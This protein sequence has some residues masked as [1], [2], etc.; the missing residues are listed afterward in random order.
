MKRQPAR[1]IGRVVFTVSACIV[2]ALTASQAADPDGEKRPFTI[3]DLYRLHDPNGV[4]LA[5]DGRSI[6]YT[7][8]S[9]DLP[10][11]K[12]QTDLYRL[13]IDGGA[14]QRLTWTEEISESS[15]AIS[16][17]GEQIA[18]VA[19]RGEQ[20][21][22][23]IW[24]L[25]TAG[26]EARPL[27]SLFTGASDPVFSPDGRFIAFVSEIYPRCGADDACNTQRDE[28][29]ANGP[30]K[31]HLADELLYRHWNAWSD[32]KVSHVM[33]VS[34]ETGELRDVTP[35]ERSAPVFSVGGGDG[36]A[37][38]PDG[39]ELCFTRNPD[40][41]ET[42][43]YSTNSDLWVVPLEP[44]EEAPA[45]ASASSVRNIT[46]GNPAWDGHPVY[47]PDGRFI[48]YLRQKQ[49]RYE[50]DLVRLTLYDR[51]T[52]EHRDMLEAFDNWVT[53][54]AW[55]RD[56]KSIV[57]LAQVGGQTPLY[58]IALAGG[59]PRPLAAFAQID[60]FTL[61]EDGQDAY[62]V[63]RA[64]G[65]PR[66]LWKLDL[67]GARP[68]Q[69]LTEHNRAL[70]D[71]VDIRP[72]ERLWVQGSEGRK[73]DVFLVKPHNFDPSRRYP[74]ILNVHGGPQ[75]Q[76]TDAFRGDWQ[77]YPGA[78]Y[79]VAFPNPHGS[80]GYGQPFTEA[81]SGDWGGRV[82]EDLMLVTDHLEKLP[83]VDAQRMGAMGWSYGGYM[84]NWFLGNTQRFK[85]IAS[86]MGIFDLSSFYYTTEELWF[87]EWDLRGTP[88]NSDDYQRW[89][90]AQFVT[91]FATPTLVITGERDYRIAYT[92]GLMTFTALRRRG[93][94]SR[95]IVMPDSGHWPSWYE[96]ALYYTA[97]LDW[98]ER[99]L[100]GGSPPWS[101]E[102]FIDNA[103]FDPQTGERI[104]VPGP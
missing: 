75:Y 94:P 69:R 37:F 78:G 28:R 13:T 4:Q 47:S 86:M 39:K 72:A 89:N 65:A 17:S 44:T 50:S 92:Q 60:E 64:V 20:A 85:A 33:L 15:P 30:L 71:E 102:D 36:F 57:F 79:I 7:L 91:E 43:A 66:E 80:T 18:F 48:A 104:D 73:I 98:F 95:L 2:I 67:S 53:D 90:P 34:V 87:P 62:A 5:P 32:G 35:G 31:A 77:V 19:Q 83:Y 76:W 21:A 10:R 52:G 29:R 93:V 51:N 27:T 11:G 38:S 41:V 9:Y 46:A 68:P 70:E 14:P 84:M 88:W 40:P 12:S 23:Q 101:V 63:R 49:P 56:S 8:R 96:M 25:P 26:G 1:R 74:L 99:H 81:I 82:F 55:R 6:V 42:L 58:E 103:V 3:E 45:N 97:H 59:K 16:P 100:K 54:F 24:L 61:S 22:P